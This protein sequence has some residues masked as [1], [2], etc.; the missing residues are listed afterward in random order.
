MNVDI[1]QQLPKKFKIDTK[2][3]SKQLPTL[4][5]F[6]NGELIDRFPP[7]NQS[8]KVAKVLRYKQKE[9]V[10]YLELDKRYYATLNK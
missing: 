5:V 9:I 8:G 4:L 1:C 7:I 10:K 2:G 3:T 6:E